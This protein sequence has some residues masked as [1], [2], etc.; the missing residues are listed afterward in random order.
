MHEHAA[1]CVYPCF[2]PK[3]SYLQRLAFQVLFRCLLAS[4]ARRCFSACR[5]LRKVEMGSVSDN[6]QCPWCRRTNGGYAPDG[7]DYPI[8]T[9]GPFSCLWHHWHDNDRTSETVVDLFDNGRALHYVFVKKF[10]VGW[11]T[12]VWQFCAGPPDPAPP[13]AESALD[14]LILIL[15]PMIESSTDVVRPPKKKRKTH[16]SYR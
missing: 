3:S 13:S 15:Q 4:R 7:V 16:R 2:G 14:H 11:C 6:Y 10:D 9:Q 8:C 12:R 5:Q 1:S